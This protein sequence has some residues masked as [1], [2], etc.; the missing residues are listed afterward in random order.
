MENLLEISSLTKQYSGFTLGP[1]DLTIPAGSVVGFVGANGAGKTTTIKS[2]LGAVKPDSGTIKLFGEDVTHDESLR[3]ALKQ[4]IGVVYDSVAFPQDSKVQDVARLGAV[5]FP[6]WNAGSFQDY[7]N[8]FG[9]QGNKKVKEL[10]RGMGMKLS[11]AFAL[12]HHPELLILD[13]ATAG[14]D[15]LA[16]DEVLDLLRR[17]MEDETH[18]IWLSSHITSDLEKIADQVVC[19][20]KGQ[21]IFDLPKDEICDL[22]GIAHC[23]WQEFD[24][25]AHSG[26]YQPGQLTYLKHEMSTDIL[27][28]DR[29]AFQEYFP[30]IA[31]DRA[32]IEDYMLICLKGRSL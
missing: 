17:F 7:C 12:S 31:C 24:Q 5:V 21:I 29:F 1:L 16:R 13:E 9:L 15:P 11:L 30:R 20:D 19:I 25:V 6:G 10:S 18:G 32:T 3:A 2:V 8:Q 27:V 4:H 14:I 28:P 26:Q 23:R 22:A